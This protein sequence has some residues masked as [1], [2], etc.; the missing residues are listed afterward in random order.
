MCIRDRVEELRLAELPA[1]VEADAAEK[2][3]RLL[4][5][6]RGLRASTLPR[7]VRDWRKVRQWPQLTRGVAWRR[8]R[9]QLE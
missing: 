9:D 8:R 3:E 5:A 7:R 2:P 1:A 6:G 4:R